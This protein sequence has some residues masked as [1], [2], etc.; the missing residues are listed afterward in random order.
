VEALLHRGVHV[1]RHAAARVEPDLDVQDLAAVVVRAALEPVALTEHGVFDDH[2]ST[3]PRA[4]EAWARVPQRLEL[5]ASR[6]WVRF[7]PVNAG[8]SG[9]FAA[10]PT[11]TAYIAAN[12][13]ST[14]TELR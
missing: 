4:F 10:L 8:R 6:G 2:A 13:G 5:R 3:V 1:R 9:D 12:A 14:R 7:A 11:L